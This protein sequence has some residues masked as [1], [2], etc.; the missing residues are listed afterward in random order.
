[1]ESNSPVCRDSIFSS[2]GRIYTG[3]RQSYFETDPQC[4]VNPI[5]TINKESLS[6]SD[7]TK[8]MRLNAYVA[9]SAGAD[10]I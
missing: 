7:G 2:V 5:R 6:R 3:V 1:M 8:Q 9:D 4:E 10:G